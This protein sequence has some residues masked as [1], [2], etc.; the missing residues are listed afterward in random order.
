[1]EIYGPSQVQGPQSIKATQRL[2]PTPNEAAVDNTPVDQV[3]ISPEAELVSQVNDLPEIRADRVAEIRAQI[4]AGTYE[5]DEKLDVAVGRLLDEIEPTS[6]AEVVELAYCRAFCR[7][8]E[9]YQ[10]RHQGDRQGAINAIQQTLR[11]VNQY[12]AMARNI[13][14]ERMLELHARL[15]RDLDEL[16]GVVV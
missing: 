1:M 11:Q 16:R 6:D 12:I 4:E 14:H 8:R 7:T 2:Q 3:D 13:G 9:A 10:L 5:T 15:D